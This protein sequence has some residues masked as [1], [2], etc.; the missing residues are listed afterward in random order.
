MLL[1]FCIL[2][3]ICLVCSVNCYCCLVYVER[4]LIVAIKRTVQTALLFVGERR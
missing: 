4:L 2:F 1:Q 3:C